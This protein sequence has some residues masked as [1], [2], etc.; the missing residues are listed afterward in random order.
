MALTF[1][2]EGLEDLAKAF[3]QLTRATQRNVLRRILTRAG[4]V[5]A[6][7]AAS[8]APVLSGRLAFSIVVSPNR[9]RR[10]RG[11][12]G[13]EFLGVDAGGR[14]VFRAE[15]K[16]SYEV[17]VGPGSGLGVLPYASFA[18]YG[19]AA[20]SAHPYMRPAYDVRRVQVLEMIKS[21]LA[22]EINKAAARAARKTARLKK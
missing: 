2:L 19:T 15:R 8:R 12:S 16:F 4:E 21:D 13:V 22:T 18:E 6:D 1:K 14:R 20:T 5:F 7:E 11:Q 9:T 17:Y 3:E 10:H